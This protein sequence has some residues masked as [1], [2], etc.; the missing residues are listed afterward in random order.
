MRVKLVVGLPL[1]L[2][3]L[4]ASDIFQLSLSWITGI[5]LFGVI[6]DIVTTAVA[7]YAAGSIEVE[8]N[9]FARESMRKHGVI[10]GLLFELFNPARLI[11][12]FLIGIVIGI[13]GFASAVFLF[14]SEP[15]AELML[16]TIVI[17]FSTTLGVAGLFNIE[18]IVVI[19]LH[20]NSVNMCSRKG[21][22]FPQSFRLD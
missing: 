18:T 14:D 21:N 7:V 16:T 4:V 19:Y 2:A 12:V 1:L 11:C 3:Y 17:Y 9:P 20:R 5:F 15:P 10:R 8:L 13:L 6:L 22:S